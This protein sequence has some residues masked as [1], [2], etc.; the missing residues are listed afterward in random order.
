MTITK[1]GKA[2]MVDLV[3]GLGGTA[4]T[5]IAYGD[6]A[7]AAVKT[8]EDLV[9]TESQR[10][11]A[12]VTQETTSDLDDTLQLVKTFTASGT[13]TIRES[14]VF[15][16]ASSGPASGVMLCR[17]VLSPVRSMLASDT[18]AATWSIKFA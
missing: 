18:W 1:L 16:S 2:E 10:E 17:Q 8:Q 11:A 7:T 15:N 3:G 4:F 12:T 13:E 14:G 5:A 6:S 9:G